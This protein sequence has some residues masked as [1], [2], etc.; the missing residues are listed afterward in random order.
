MRRRMEDAF[1][2][3]HAEQEMKNRTME[4]LA[5]TAKG[6]K[7]KKAAPVGRLIAA[8]ACLVIFLSAGIGYSAY[9]LPAFSISIDVNPSIELGINYFN[10]VVSVDTFNEDGSAVMSDMDVY[11]LNYMDALEMILADSEMEKYA[12]QEQFVAVTVFGKN[13]ERND[14]LLD[15]VSACMSSYGNVHCAA[16]NSR[17]AAAARKAG[18]SPGRY[19]ALLELQ[20]LDPDI[21]AEDIQEL[22]M[23]QIWDWIDELSGNAEGTGR[24]GSTGRRGRGRHKGCG[25]GHGRGY[26]AYP[27]EDSAE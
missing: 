11:N 21:T 20:S 3:L 12:A 14:E 16:G 25:R 6:Y 17:E 27:Q 22:T 19:K 23:C 8:A 7:K 26:G 15:S 24:D 4:F 5:D 9:L 1:G 2:K 10:K 13:D 18:M